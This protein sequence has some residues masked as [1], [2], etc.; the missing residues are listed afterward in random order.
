MSGHCNAKGEKNRSGLR[1][2]QWGD[3]WAAAGGLLEQPPTPVKMGGE[4]N[5]TS[6]VSRCIS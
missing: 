6:R 1:G 3:P 4:K 5:E 2:G